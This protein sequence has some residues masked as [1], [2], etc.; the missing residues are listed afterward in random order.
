MHLEIQPMKRSALLE[1]LADLIT[2]LKRPHPLRV[3]IDGVDAAGKT[4]L[5]DELVEPVQARGLVV[6]R[7]S[8]DGFHNPQRVRYRRGP[9]SPAGY[10]LDS[11]DYAALK[12]LLLEPLG[13]GGNLRYR[14]AAF[15]YRS[16]SVLNAP[17][18]LA[19]PRSVLLFDGVFLLRPALFD[20]WDFKLFV[21]V[22]LAIAMQRACAR[23]QR[24]SGA[25]DTM[26]DKYRQRYGPGQRIYLRQCCPK[27][28]ADAIVANDNLL[29]PSLHLQPLGG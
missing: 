23:H 21:D 10:Y 17:R 26:R 12:S 18:R 29:D 8:I 13:P 19:N 5:A 6:I 2:S 7:A 11:F 20:F 15:D 24:Q 14:T 27:E 28:R 16:D 9:N 25:I 22:D 4:T 1:Q 3:A